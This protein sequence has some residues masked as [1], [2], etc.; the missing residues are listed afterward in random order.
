MKLWLFTKQREAD[1]EEVASCVIRSASKTSAARIFEKEHFASSDDYDI[2]EL[3]VAGK[4]GIICTDVRP[5]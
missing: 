5:S 2:E 1:Y 4:S 3:K